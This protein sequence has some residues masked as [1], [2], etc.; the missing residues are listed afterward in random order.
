[1]IR[2]AI[3]G[4]SLLALSGSAFAATSHQ[5]VS[6]PRVVAQAGAPAG[7]TAAPAGD[8]ADKKAKKSKKDKGTKTEGKT[9]GAKEMKAP[10]PTPAK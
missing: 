8:K 10:A 2:N 5:H 7:D 9:E 4:M 3:F 1:M 6:K